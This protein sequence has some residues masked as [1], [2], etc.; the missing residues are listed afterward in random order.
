MI[1]ERLLDLLADEATVGLTPTEGEELA[2]LLAS[3]PDVDGTSMERAA[4][5]STTPNDAELPQGLRAKLQADAGKYFAVEN[6]A[7]PKRK[8]WFANAGWIV[9]ACLLLAVALLGRSL[10]NNNSRQVTPFTVA[11]ALET[12]EK[13]AGA[14]VQRFATKPSPSVSGNVVWSGTRQEGYIQVS[15]LKPN[16]PSKKQYQLWIVDKGRTHKEPVDGGVFDV[17]ANGTALVPIR[18]PLK[19][20]D[21]AAFAVTEEPAGGVVVSEA[22]KRGE[23]VVLMVP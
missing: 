10:M 6:A 2:A 14:N 1:P 18:S 13:D 11:Q 15:G 21:P 22:G 9:A 8:N 3:F 7:P 23:F 17:D 16:D 5:I 12:L 4:A 19:I 20:S